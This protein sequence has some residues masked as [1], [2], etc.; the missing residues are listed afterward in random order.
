MKCVDSQLPPE[1]EKPVPVA[2]LLSR[3]EAFGFVLI[4]GAI[5]ILAFVA[6]AAGIGFCLFRRLTGF[7]CP[8]CGTT[9]A[10][11][12]VL[13]GD[14]VGALT[15]NPLA[16]VLIFLGPFIVWLMTLRRTWPRAVVITTTVLGWAAVLL[17]WAYLLF[18]DLS[19][20]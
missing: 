13:R 3:K 12:A 1:P 14:F 19:R 15:Y 9:R 10:C 18:R 11:L 16:V 17:N 5:G 7:S 20:G 6:H 8:C 2:G 4:L